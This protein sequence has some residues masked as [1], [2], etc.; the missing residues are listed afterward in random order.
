MS[1][2]PIRVLL[3]D[4]EPELVQFLSKRLKRKGLEATEAT[5]GKEGLKL[6]RKHNFDVAVLDLKMP[7]MDGLQVLREL[8]KI[9]PFIQVV[10]LTG[11]GSIETALESG[12][13]QAF[14]FLAKPAEFNELVT[15]IEEGADIKRKELRQAFDDEV[16]ELISSSMDPADILAETK[17]LRQKYDQ[18][19]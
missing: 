16:A 8:R 17:R 19:K 5:S 13:E 9:Q 10:M 3:V 7:E 2:T 12:R 18:M 14:R 1:D 6:A 11:H 15:V 4:D